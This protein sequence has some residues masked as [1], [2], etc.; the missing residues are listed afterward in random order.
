MSYFF[1]ELTQTQVLLF[2]T[3]TN[4]ADQIV[5]RLTI[6]FYVNSGTAY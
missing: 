4:E 3:L 2:C 6:L 1:P 5:Q